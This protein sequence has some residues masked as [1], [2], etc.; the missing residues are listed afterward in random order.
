[1]LPP[2]NAPKSAAGA[3]L[4]PSNIANM[5]AQSKALRTEIAR[6]DL[7]GFLFMHIVP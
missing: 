1:M 7:V 4:T 2:T 3:G 6:E 5:A